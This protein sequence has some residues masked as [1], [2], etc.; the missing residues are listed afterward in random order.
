MI[1]AGKIACMGSE[2][3]IVRP[4]IDRKDGEQDD[5]RGRRPDPRHGLGSRGGL[6]YQRDEREART[7]PRQDGHGRT[8]TSG[9]GVDRSERFALVASC[10]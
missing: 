4:M 5:E 2:K 6:R 10:R 3:T 8:A 1:P 7:R 9:N